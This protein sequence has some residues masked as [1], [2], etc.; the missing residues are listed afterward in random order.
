[1]AETKTKQTNQSVTEFIYSFTE[2]E[3]KRQDS[4]ELIELMKNFTGHEPDRKSVV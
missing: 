1:M 4:F 3:Q 2:T